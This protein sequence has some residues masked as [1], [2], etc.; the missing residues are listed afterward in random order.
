MKPDMINNLQTGGVCSIFVILDQIQIAWDQRGKDHEIMKRIL[1][2]VK[3]DCF[4][5]GFKPY[6]SYVK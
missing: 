4:T 3:P 5:K 1:H 2:S 6:E